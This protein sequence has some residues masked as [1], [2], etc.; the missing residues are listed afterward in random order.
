VLP[1]IVGTIQAT[2]AI[3]VLLGIGESLSGKLLT[4]N[5]LNMK[6]RTL[7]IYRDEDCPVCDEFKHSSADEEPQPVRSGS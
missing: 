4:F 3:K 2:E 5:T 7:K 6:F 1:G